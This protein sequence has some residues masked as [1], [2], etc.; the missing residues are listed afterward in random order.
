MDDERLLIEI[1]RY[2]FLYNN[3]EPLYKDT[4]VKERAWAEIA[5]ALGGVSG[6]HTN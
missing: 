2:R 3:R 6:K 4:K 1:E 5:A